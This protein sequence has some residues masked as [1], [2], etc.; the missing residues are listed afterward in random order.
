MIGWMLMNSTPPADKS[1]DMAE[2]TKVKTDLSTSFTVDGTDDS[3]GEIP[4]VTRLLN[5][6][7]FGKSASSNKTAPP[8]ELASTASV[9]PP[10]AP[11]PIQKDATS[12]ALS[13]CDAQDP[14]VVIERIEE[15]SPAPEA[16][17]MP[18]LPEVAV[19][20]APAAVQEAPEPAAEAD[21]V[22]GV[23]SA[24]AAAPEQGTPAQG[25]SVTAKK[26]AG[27]RNRSVT[28][29]KPLI[30]WTPSA[31]KS[32]RDPLAQALTAFLS[33]GVTQALFLAIQPPP[34]G[35][36]APIFAATAAVNAGAKAAIWAGLNWDPSIL[37]HVWAQ[38]ISV[39]FSEQPPPGSMTDIQS[40]RNVARS[41]FDVGSDEFLVIIR[42]GNTQLC[43]GLLVLI[44]PKSMLGHVQKLMSTLSATA[45]SAAPAKKSA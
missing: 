15:H 3:E 20:A 8:A 26:S 44:S 9:T 38:I 16:I 30:V 21:P 18:V 10:H 24:V 1:T 13:L 11:A 36:T 27:R 22:A 42:V 37:P 4:S 12:V 32:D 39:G 28:P 34:P 5:R 31:L 35:S 7:S 2:N 40:A 14:P 25:V 33:Y 29:Q 45:A 41:A 19:A 43:R 17:P 23:D 6:K